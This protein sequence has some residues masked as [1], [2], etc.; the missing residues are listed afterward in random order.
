MAS[1][2]FVFRREIFGIGPARQQPP[3]LV[4]GPLA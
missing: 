4:L 2:F 3:F 1:S